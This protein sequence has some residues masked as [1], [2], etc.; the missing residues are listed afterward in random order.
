GVGQVVDRDEIQVADP[1]GLGGANHVPTDPAKAID[2]DA[3]GHCSPLSSRE[4][5]VARLASRLPD[6]CQVCAQSWASSWLALA[7]V[8]A[9]ILAAPA[10][11][12]AAP[13]ETSVAPV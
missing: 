3:N 13:A 10:A 9:S 5:R 6:R 8:T 12:N 7:N 1:H 2:A 4:S 11:A